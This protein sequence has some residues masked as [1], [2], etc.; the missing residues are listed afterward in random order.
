VT[1]SDAGQVLLTRAWESPLTAPWTEADAAWVS[2]Q[3]TREA[4]DAAG[5]ASWL[6]RRARLAVARLS[7]RGAPV[8]RAL[9]AVRWP[10]WLGPALVA[11]AFGAGLLADRVGAAERINLLAPPVL[12]LLAWNVFVYL[13]LAVGIL[14]GGDAPARALPRALAGLLRR[15]ADDAPVA[16][17]FAADFARATAPLQA[18]RAAAALHAA[19]AALALGVLASLYLRGLAF[20]YRAGW[21]STFLDAAQVRALLGTVLGPAS[22]LSGI[23]L[24]DVAR[25]DALRFSSGGGENAARWIHLHALTALLVVLLPRTLLAWRAAAAARRLADALPLPL[26]EPYFERLLRERRGRPLAA[27]VLPYSYRL[28]ERQRDGLHA[29]LGERFGRV[30][31]RLDEVPLGGEDDAARWA[32]PLPDGAR[33]IVL[34]ALTATPEAE[35]H[36]A[37]VDALRAAAPFDVWIDESGFRERIADEARRE[38]RRDAWRRLLAAHGVEP[39]FV[40]LGAG[41]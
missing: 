37:F 33:R 17:R 25:L 4:G 22:T 3:A 9:A 7:E 27:Q 21:D 41:G 18:A 23:S 29:R 6:A 13:L 20:E 35:H 26:G 10:A 2:R 12:A 8:T 28:G 19:A 11:A 34:F 24:P 16:A 14:R 5:D 1:E 40:D 15:R 38:Q 39:Q 32:G 30:E 36:G 31:L